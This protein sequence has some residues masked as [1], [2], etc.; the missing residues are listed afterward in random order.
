MSISG[1]NVLVSSNLEGSEESQEKVPVQPDNSLLGVETLVSRLSQI[2]GDVSTVVSEDFKGDPEPCV[3]LIGENCLDVW[4]QFEECA[5]P[6]ISGTAVEV[7]TMLN[8]LSAEKTSLHEK[9]QTSVSSANAAFLEGAKD[10]YIQHL[11]SQEADQQKAKELAAHKEKCEEERAWLRSRTTGNKH[12]PVAN[13]MAKNLA[14]VLAGGIVIYALCE[15]M[16]GFDIFRFRGSYISA[17][18][19]SATLIAGLTALTYLVAKTSKK[20]IVQWDAHRKFNHNFPGGVDLETGE[21][22]PI[23]ARPVPSSIETVLMAISSFILFNAITIGV[24]VRRIG[25]ANGNHRLQSQ[26]TSSWMLIGAS[27]IL[28]L[29]ELYLIS[30]YDQKDIDEDKRLTEAIAQADKA[31]E[32]LKAKS[33]EADYKPVI[34]SYKEKIAAARSDANMC[35]AQKLA[36][37]NQFAG[38]NAEYKLAYRSVLEG[39]ESSIQDFLAQIRLDSRFEFSEET[40]M[41]IEDPATV[42]SIVDSFQKQLRPLDYSELVGEIQKMNFQIQFPEDLRIVEF[43]EVIAKAEEVVKAELASKAQVS[44]VAPVSVEAARPATIS[45]RPL[46]RRMYGNRS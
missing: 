42:A 13:E 29:V 12:T 45:V 19:I 3:Q 44:T 16:G 20:L 30:G 41:S 38:M 25:E 4:E 34:A 5:R 22:V 43:A 15:A 28:L 11:A 40:L 36:R 8:T 33:Q 26:V 21:H 32:A 17:F 10:V 39:F 9:L 7:E 14:I 2:R 24:L 18:G 6:K 23:Q 31:I 1:V 35:V 37:I 27:W 46:R